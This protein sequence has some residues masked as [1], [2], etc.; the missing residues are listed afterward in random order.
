MHQPQMLQN[1]LK[2][3]AYLLPPAPAGAKMYTSPVLPAATKPLPRCTTACTAY[4][5]TAGVLALPA[6]CQGATMLL[7]PLFGLLA[8][9]DG[10]AACTAPLTLL[11]LLPVGVARSSARTAAPAAPLAVPCRLLAGLMSYT[12]STPVGLQ[13]MILPV[14]V[15]I[16]IMP[17]TRWH[18]HVTVVVL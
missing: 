1:P 17:P 3:L 18:R 6:S 9:E 4:K 16:A 8:T 15:P 2:A 14:F 11:L 5:P 12:D 10:L 7:L 13:I